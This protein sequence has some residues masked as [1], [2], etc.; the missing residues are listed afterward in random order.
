[1]N[2]DEAQARF[3]YGL[4]EPHELGKKLTPIQDRVFGLKKRGLNQV[5]IANE[6]GLSQGTI[7][8][9]ILCIRAKGHF[10]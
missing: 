10:V 5:Q 1:M 2:K 7:Y 8:S 6:L 4:E 3:I 9:H